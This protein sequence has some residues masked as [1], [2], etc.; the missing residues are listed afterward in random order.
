[1]LIMLTNFVCCVSILYG[2]ILLIVFP[3]HR[4]MIIFACVV[5]TI[6]AHAKNEK[7]TLQGVNL[8]SK[9]QVLPYT[10]HAYDVRC[11]TLFRK[12]RERC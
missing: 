7:V 5:W 3:V 6:T 12:V 1:M 9:V 11:L 4:G 8:N 10:G 2:Q